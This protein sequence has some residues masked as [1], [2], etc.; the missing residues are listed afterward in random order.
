M[1]AANLDRRITI[2]R[3]TEGTD[4]YGNPVLTEN[5]VGTFYAS[6]R[7]QS[8]AEAVRAG[9]LSPAKTVFFKLR[10]IENIDANDKI[11]SDGETFQI[12]DVRVIGRRE[13]LEIRAE[14]S[15]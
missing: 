8:G 15:T 1:R 11:V 2:I 7:Q 6:R 14:L 12:S 3:V 13:G 10:Y 9:T 5:T 4:P